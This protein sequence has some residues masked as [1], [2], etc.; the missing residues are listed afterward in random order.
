MGQIARNGPFY[1]RLAG[2]GDMAER[3][4]VALEGLVSAV[5][6]SDSP[7]GRQHA[8]NVPTPGLWEQSRPVA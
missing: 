2:N 1:F 3:S 8:T 4:Q 7:C 5:I 6:L